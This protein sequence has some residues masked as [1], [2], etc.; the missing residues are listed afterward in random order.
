MFPVVLRRIAYS[1]ALRLL[2]FTLF[3]LLNASGFGGIASG[4]SL[5]LLLCTGGSSLLLFEL[6]GLPGCVAIP[7]RGLGVKTVY[8]L[9]A[10]VVF[11]FLEVLHSL[12]GAL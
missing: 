11:L 10:T 4:A 3:T 12:V 8:F 6:A 5:L 1:L 7:S 9:A 2:G